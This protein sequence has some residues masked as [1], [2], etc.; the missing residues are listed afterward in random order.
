[1]TNVKYIDLS[2]VQDF[3]EEVVLAKMDMESLL[4]TPQR[5]NM[6]EFISS[7]DISSVYVNAGNMISFAIKPGRDSI[8]VFYMNLQ[9]P[10]AEQE[11]TLEDTLNDMKCALEKTEYDITK[12]N[13]KT[14]AQLIEGDLNYVQRGEF[15][16]IRNEFYVV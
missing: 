11:K 5:M 6:V 16:I 1:M 4:E 13:K 14:T 8:Y 7:L 9:N 2:T 10:Y 3:P 12:L 15:F